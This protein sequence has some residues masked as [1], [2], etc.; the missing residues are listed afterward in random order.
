MALAASLNDKLGLV[1]AS[2]L[3]IAICQIGILFILLNNNLL[4]AALV[5][6]DCLWYFTQP[7]ILYSGKLPFF[8]T[9]IKSFTKSNT[10]PETNQLHY[11]ACGL[12]F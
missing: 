1:Q 8:V 3:V 4:M 10:L 9:G 5:L 6:D 2:R 7:K 12:N 11:G